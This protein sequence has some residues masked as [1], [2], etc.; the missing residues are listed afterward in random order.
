[1]RERER[2]RERG[3]EGEEEY[4]GEILKRECEKER[5]RGKGVL[6]CLLKL[7]RERKQD[8]FFLVYKTSFLNKEIL[9]T[10]P[11]SPSVRVPG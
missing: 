1:M 4:E 8:N 10:E 6:I 7:V 9:C 11:F 3:R 2:E 5:E